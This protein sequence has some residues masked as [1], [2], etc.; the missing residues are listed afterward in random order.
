M[1]DPITETRLFK[2]LEGTESSIQDIT[3]AM[4]EAAHVLAY[5]HLG[6]LDSQVGRRKHEHRTEHWTAAI[7]E[8][9]PA[10][11]DCYSLTAAL[12]VTD[13]INKVAPGVLDA[14]DDWEHLCAMTRLT[15]DEIR[16]SEPWRE[17]RDWL[18][19]R[20]GEIGE[21]AVKIL[22]GQEVFRWNADENDAT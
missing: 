12:I 15:A 14:L 19:P 9:V 1:F 5:R 11:V 20:R 18:L 7:A 10:S 4:H 6:H 17:M 2:L 16:D 3:A 8:D 21:I 13:A 22:K